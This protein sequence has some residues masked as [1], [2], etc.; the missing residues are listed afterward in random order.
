[1]SEKE[2]KIKSKLFEVPVKAVVLKDGKVLVLKRASGNIRSAEKY[3]FPGG[4]VEQ[5]E[6]V[7]NAL[8]REIKEET[9]LIVEVGPVIFV[10]DSEKEYALDEERKNKIKTFTIGIGF[11]AF[12]KNGEVKLSDE[13]QSFEW[14]NIEDAIK[15]FDGKNMFYDRKKQML[16]KAVEYL[17][18]QN[19]VDSWKRCQADFEN[20]KKDQA[21]SR[22]EFLKFAKMDVISQ[23]LPVLDN[24]E[25]SLKHV[26][27][28]QKKSGWVTGI[29]HIQKQV[30]DVLKNNGVSEIEVK[31]GDKF[32][33][34]IQEAFSGKGESVKKILQK[35]Y[36][37][38]GRVIR[39]SK[40]EV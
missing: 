31:V 10:S 28:D 36:K 25:A 35:G 30:Q 11:L 20:Y 22:E 37:L 34:E 9:N 2:E 13:H 8:D 23:I 12:Y 17:R 40:V 4:T 33:P 7:I 21:K 14:L 26:P 27:E 3:D 39:A 1:M 38:N 29:T 6:S 18:N 5:G 32:D 16:I 19:A 15:K 24:F